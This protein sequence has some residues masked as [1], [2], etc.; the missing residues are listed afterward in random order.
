MKIY[1]GYLVWSNGSVDKV[2]SKLVSLKDKDWREMSHQSFFTKGFTIQ[3][4]F[5]QLSFQPR[6]AIWIS[7]LLSHSHD[8][9]SVEFAAN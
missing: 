3:I 5:E 7:W 2:K 8:S 4:G 1:I 6:S 9:R